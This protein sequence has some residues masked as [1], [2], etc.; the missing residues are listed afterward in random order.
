MIPRDYQVEMAGDALIILREHNMAYLAAEE[1]TGKTLTAIL[2]AEKSSAQDVLIITKKKALDGWKETLA[3]FEHKTN[4]VLTNYHQA[5]KLLGNYDLVILD[6]SHN[7]ISAFPKIGVT[8]AQ[9]T[10]MRR[11]GKES[12]NIYDAVRRICRNTPVLY[13]SATPHAQ[14]PQMLFHQFSVCSWSPWRMYD[15]FYQWF[16]KYGKPY[17]VKLNSME[18]NQYDKCEVQK[19]MSE[20]SH[21]FITKT[22]ASLGFTHEPE[23]RLHYIELSEATSYWY[24]KLIEDELIEL[25]AGLLVCDTASKL[26]VSLHAIEGGTVKLDSTGVILANCEKMQYI[27]DNFGDTETLVIM[28]HFQAELI[29]LQRRFT[30]ATLLQATS[31]AEG[32]DLHKY[33]HLIIYSQDYSTARHTQRRARQCNMHRDKPIVV[34]HLLV[35]G[36]ISEQVFKTVCVNKKNFVDSV[37]KRTKI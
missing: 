4:F 1:R 5:W 33:E 17:T 7:Y 21:L 32:V 22:R 18:V 15:N 6:E 12:T 24:N 36:G 16:K 28:Y 26:R 31:Y 34:H 13:L 11:E 2:V 9:R 8:A 37:F 29:K 14:G 20:V 27:V 23:D 35:K 19:I 30:K 10:V 3:A 25:D